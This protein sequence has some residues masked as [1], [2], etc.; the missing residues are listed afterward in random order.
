MK[1][2]WFFIV[3]CAVFV[4]AV[5]NK[6][7]KTS[8]WDVA[9]RN[10]VWMDQN[11]I[12]Y[13]KRS[14]DVNGTNRFKIL[15]AWKN[16][17][18]DVNQYFKDYV[19]RYQICVEESLKKYYS[20]DPK[21]L[22]YAYER[23]YYHMMGICSSYYDNNINMLTYCFDLI[24]K[25]FHSEQSINNADTIPLPHFTILVIIFVWMTWFLFC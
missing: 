24:A 3:F 20:D 19:Y 18:T 4:F 5:G 6:N 11:E 12:S 23:L 25:K 8:V 7:D 15:C 1:L 14:E 17:E 2:L 16:I 22:K 13:S 21:E 10:I 9:K